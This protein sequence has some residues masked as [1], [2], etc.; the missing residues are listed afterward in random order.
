MKAVREL[1]IEKY[2]AIIYA[3][4][5]HFFPLTK[6]PITYSLCVSYLELVICLNI[7]E[8]TPSCFHSILNCLDVIAILSGE[9]LQPSSFH[10]TDPAVCLLLWVNQQWP[11]QAI[12][13]QDGILCWI[14]TKEVTVMPLADLEETIR[15]FVVS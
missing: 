5:Y 10:L 13:D 11:L 6:L 9:L 14:L 4:I 12:L 1:N 2:I 3:L 7:Q 15:V 8:D